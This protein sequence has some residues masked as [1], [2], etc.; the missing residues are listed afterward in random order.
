M[1]IED[2]IKYPKLKYIYESPSEGRELLGKLVFFQEKRDGSNMRAFLDD[3]NNIQFGSRNLIPP[4]QDLIAS[5]FNTGYVDTLKEA[6]YTEKHQWN[7]NIIIFF[8]L[9]QKGVSPTRVE[10]HEKDDIAVFDIYDIENGWW[11]YNRVYQFCYQW[12]LPI[13][14]LWAVTS[15]STIEKLKEQIEKMLDRAREEGREGVVYKTYEGGKKIS[16]KARLDVPDMKRVEVDIDPERPKLPELPEAEIMNEIQKV[17]EE[18]GLEQFRDKKV[19]MPLIAQYVA[20]EC[21]ARYCSTPKGLY[22]YYLK[23]LEEVNGK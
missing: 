6:L 18:L 1:R 17:L 9:L 19:A 22:T 2:V 16:Y 23:K 3:D 5:V 4:S 8:E 14:K 7:H 13:V 11:N 12:R 15:H 10:K 20:A 21:K